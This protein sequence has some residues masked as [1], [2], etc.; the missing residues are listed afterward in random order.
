MVQI[1]NEINHGI[2]WQTGS[3]KNYDS[4]ATLIKAGITAVKEV[5]PSIK[6][7][8]H[9]ALGGQ[10]DES[11]M[12]LDNMLQRNV[13]FDIIG[14][15][16]YPQWH[17]TLDDLKNNLNDLITRY[18]QDIIVAEY[19][20]HKKEVNEIAFSLPN[21]NFVGTFIWEPLNTWEFIFDKKGNTIDSLIN[22]YPE[23]KKKYDV[24]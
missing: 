18:K 20:A 1:G 7:M 2:L 10:N 13:Q 5:D 21:K 12:F 8:L 11:R 14:E 4:L 24:E 17:G 15:S 19:T 23:I 6:I 22:I 16:Y 3:S 9:I